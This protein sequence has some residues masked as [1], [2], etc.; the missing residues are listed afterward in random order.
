MYVCMYV[1]VYVS[2]YVCMYVPIPVAVRSMAWVSSRLLAD[3]TGSNPRRRHDCLCVM[4]DVCCQ[5][6]VS[7]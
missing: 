6:E 2:M 5:V 3:T 1:C 4:S 7:A